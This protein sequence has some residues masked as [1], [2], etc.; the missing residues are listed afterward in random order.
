MKPSGSKKVVLAA[1]AGN[2]AIAVAKFAAAAV[3]GSS[4]MLSEAIHSVVD[5]GNQGLLLYGIRR[6]GRPADEDHPFGY[7]MELYFWTFVVAILIFAGGAGVS[8]YQGVV[9]LANPQPIVDAHVNYIVLGVAL[10]LEA[11]AWW[12]AFK[13]FAKSKGDLGTL[14]AVHRSKD[15]AVFTVLFEDS[16][17]IAGLIIAAVGI[18][19]SDALGEPRWDGIGSIVI[20]AVL[21]ATAALLAYECKG[22]LI[23]EGAGRRV[24]RGLR[25]IAAETEGVARINEALTMHLGPRDVLLN[26]SLDFDD[27][28][29]SADVERTISALERAIK[30]AYPEITR[31]FI[32]AQSRAGH[33]RDRRNRQSNPQSDA[34]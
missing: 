27:R 6:A 4:S 3:T 15:P 13:E 14:E 12:I 28:L 17:A 19:L 24:V 29:S 20:G 22:L 30:A 34:G 5:T 11:G 26:L 2:A 23:G 33:R 16:A 31:V 32:E 18:G 1:L 25:R 9:K 21:A 10:V 8:V 7:G